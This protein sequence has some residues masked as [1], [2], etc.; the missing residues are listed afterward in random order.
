MD[1]KKESNLNDLILTLKNLDKEKADK[2]LS[3]IEKE[4][5]LASCIA[6]RCSIKI[7]AHS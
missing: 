7:H 3:I 2:I 6:W 5:V 1:E 4:G